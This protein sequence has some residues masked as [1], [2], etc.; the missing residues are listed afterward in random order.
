MS[1]VGLD[2]DDFDVLPMPHTYQC[3]AFSCGSPLMDHALRHELPTAI[4]EGRSRA[5]YIE[6]YGR[7]VGFF[8]LHASLLEID[9]VDK[10]DRGYTFSVKDVP[11][12]VLEMLA[13]DISYQKRGF[14]ERLTLEAL[15]I[16]QEVAERIGAF[17]LVADSTQQAVELYERAG[18]LPTRIQPPG[19]TRRMIIEIS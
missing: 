17:L 5:Y 16:A 14:G 10:D 6:H 7:C 18:F 3:G 13:V 11:G 19:M 4:R 12:I 9:S 8:S 15:G 2:P 1:L